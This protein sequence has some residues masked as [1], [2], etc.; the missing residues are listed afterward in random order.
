MTLETEEVLAIAEKIKPL[1]AGHR[2]EMQ[3]AVLAE[4]TSIW[5]G[6]HTIKGKRGETFKLRK[7]VLDMHNRAIWILMQL[8]EPAKKGSKK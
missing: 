4:L 2:P 7:D 6:G 5:L 8:N 3:G 1:L